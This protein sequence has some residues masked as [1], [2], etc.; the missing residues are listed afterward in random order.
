MAARNA[1]RQ[2]LDVGNALNRM[3]ATDDDTR[4]RKG[5]QSMIFERIQA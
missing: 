4:L 5:Y 2:T 3:F 1:R